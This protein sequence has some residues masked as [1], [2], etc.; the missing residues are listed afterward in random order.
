MNLFNQRASMPNKVLE[1]EGRNKMPVKL[2]A[3]SRMSRSE[4]STTL[5]SVAASNSSGF[6]HS[7]N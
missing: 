5:P 2:R 3:M 7:A 4:R 6:Q 1:R